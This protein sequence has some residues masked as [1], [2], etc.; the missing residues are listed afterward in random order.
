MASLPVFSGLIGVVVYMATLGQGSQLAD[1]SILQGKNWTSVAY[2]INTSDG[3]AQP[4]QGAN[5]ITA[6]IC[7]LT[8]GAPTSVCMASP[9]GATPSGTAGPAGG[10]QSSRDL[11]AS[12]AAPSPD[13]VNPAKSRGY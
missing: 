3:G 5:L 2:S 6:A 1:G 12:P 4:R 11:S 8:Q 7:K 10:A 13:R 9:I